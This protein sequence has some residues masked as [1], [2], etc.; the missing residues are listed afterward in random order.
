MLIN[1]P[2]VSIVYITTDPILLHQP[3]AP[4]PREYVEGE[5]KQLRSGSPNLFLSPPALGQSV[6]PFRSLGSL[7]YSPIHLA[8]PLG[9]YHPVPPPGDWKRNTPTRNPAPV[10]PNPKLTLYATPHTPRCD[11]LLT[12]EC[13]KPGGWG[14]GR[15][16]APPPPE[17]GGEGSRSQK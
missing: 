8:S 14:F 4:V 17:V 9:S 10:Y 12:P 7:G 5:E 15:T 16:H 3:K 2:L 11:A 6:T 13:L 1:L